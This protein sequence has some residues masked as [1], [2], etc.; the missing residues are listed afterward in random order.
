MAELPSWARSLIGPGPL[1]GWLERRP[2]AGR[3]VGALVLLAARLWL[4]WPFFHSGTLRVGNWSGQAFLF[5]EV[6]PVP[7]LPP[8]LAA[9]VTTAAELALPLALALG[10]LTRP[11]ALGLAAMAASIYFVIGQTPE[12]LENGI[13]V[14]AEQL[15]WM[16]VGLALVV[17]GGGPASA[18]ALILR[19][20]R[21]TA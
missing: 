17:S 21:G 11:A 2:L 5:S 10:L 15:P 18:D 1:G 14:A 20:T 9:L 4:A 8:D 7:F 6:H 19:L 13:A 16:A 3:L 12:G